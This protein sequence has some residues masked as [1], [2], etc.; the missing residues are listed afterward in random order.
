[1]ND[2]NTLKKP[3]VLILRVSINVV[4]VKLELNVTNAKHAKRQRMSNQNKINLFPIINNVMKK[5]L[6]YFMI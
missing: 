3:L 2:A 6:I 1:M 4:R 5:S